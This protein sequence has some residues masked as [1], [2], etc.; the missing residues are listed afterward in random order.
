MTQDVPKKSW[1]ARSPREQEGGWRALV[2]DDSNSTRRSGAPSFAVVQRAGAGNLTKRS[3]DM[4]LWSGRADLN[5]RPLAPQAS[6][7]P[8]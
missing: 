8:G 3:Y 4:L 6:A 2:S 1:V 5:C 7:L